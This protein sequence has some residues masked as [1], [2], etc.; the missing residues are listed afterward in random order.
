MMTVLMTPDEVAA[1][2]GVHKT[3]VYR[4]CSK[5]DGLRC[6]KVGSRIRFK[7]EDVDDYLEHCLVKPP[8]A[9]AGPKVTR[10]QY[11]PGMRVVSL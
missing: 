5:T 6:Y 11:K 8:Q 3:T 10:F 1:Q 2:L 7:P 9:Q 4:L